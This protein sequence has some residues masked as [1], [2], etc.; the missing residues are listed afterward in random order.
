MK[1]N[2]LTRTHVRTNS[3]RK[4]ALARIYVVADYRLGCCSANSFTD[5]LP[6]SPLGMLVESCAVL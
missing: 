1:K 3:H 2:A 6:G 4:D 5:F